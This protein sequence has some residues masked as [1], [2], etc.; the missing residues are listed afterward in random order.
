MD[1]ELQSDFDVTVSESETT[2]QIIREAAPEENNSFI[3]R[4]SEL[5][6]N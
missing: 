1:D 2:R 4:T 6:I 3:K 5:N